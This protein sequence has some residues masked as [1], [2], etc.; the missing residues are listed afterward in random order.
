MSLLKAYLSR[1]STKR[2]LNRKPGQDGFS[3][4][5]LV[6]VVAVLAILSAIAIPQFSQLSD[7]A[8]LNSAKSILANMY[9]ECEFNKARTGT[10]F[11]TAQT[12]G[13]PNGVFWDADAEIALQNGTGCDGRATAKMGTDQAGAAGCIISMNMADGTTSYDNAASS[14]ADDSADWEDNFPANAS[15]CT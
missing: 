10:G 3:L 9:K 4:I 12:N 7:D 8:R 2:A 14:P 6:V 1:P 13:T 11:H 15:D 5:E